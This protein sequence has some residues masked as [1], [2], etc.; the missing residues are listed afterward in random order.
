MLQWEGTISVCRQSKH[1]EARQVE[2][3]CFLSVHGTDPPVA[4]VRKYVHLLDQ[5][6]LDYTEEI[7]KEV[8]INNCS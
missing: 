8:A 4:L 7:G 2:S 3:A 1:H 5:G 6:D